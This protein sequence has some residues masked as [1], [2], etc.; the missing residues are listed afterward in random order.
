MHPQGRLPLYLL[1]RLGTAV[2]VDVVVV[3]VLGALLAD[4]GPVG[5]HGQ[6]EPSLVRAQDR[7]SGGPS[8]QHSLDSKASTA[9]GPVLRG[10]GAGRVSYHGRGLTTGGLQDSGK[11]FV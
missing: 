7:R 10:A 6:S 11:M 1:F 9:E 3:D 5:S 2:M 8:P 4:E